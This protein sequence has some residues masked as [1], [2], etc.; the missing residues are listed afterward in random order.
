M[1]LGTTLSLNYFIIDENILRIKQD[2]A[3]YSFNSKNSFNNRV[4]IGFLID[5]EINQMLGE[6]LS[7]V[8]SFHPQI[9]SFE[10]FYLMGSPDPWFVM[11]LNISI[12]FRYN[13]EKTA[14]LTCQMLNKNF[15]TNSY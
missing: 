8:M 1:M 6:R 11:W 14:I 15:N 4:G 13:L 12:S 9:T 2:L 10:K 3:I 7:T 5:Y